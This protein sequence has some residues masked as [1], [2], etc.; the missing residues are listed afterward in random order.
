MELNIISKKHGTKTIYFDDDDYELVNKYKWA[1]WWSGYGFYAKH[2]SRKGYFLLHQLLMGFP[3]N[4]VDHIDCDGLNNRRLNLRVVTDGQSSA[5][6]RKQKNNTTGYKGVFFVAHTKRYRVSVN[7]N[8]ERIEGGY[9][10]SVIDAAKKYNE[11]ALEHWGEYANLNILT[12]EES[13]KIPDKKIKR[14]A[15]NNTT[16]Y[17]GVYKFREKFLSTIA[18]NKRL[19]RVGLF[20]TKNEAAAAYNEAALNHFGDNANLNIIING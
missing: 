13:D 4:K 15:K 12:K 10:D 20:A 3:K 17:R 18:V 1:I 5:N 19:I 14:S 9:F 16:G 2:S 8:G 6:R 11:L 7:K